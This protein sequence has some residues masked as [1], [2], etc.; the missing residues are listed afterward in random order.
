MACTEHTMYKLKPLFDITELNINSPIYKMRN[1]QKEHGSEIL[2]EGR[3]TSDSL[4]EEI[5]GRQDIL[6]KQIQEIKELLAFVKEKIT[7]KMGSQEI[8]SSSSQPNVEPEFFKLGVLHEV[9]LNA[10][11]KN[12]PNS[13][14]ALHKLWPDI[15]FSLSWH[16]HSSVKGFPKALKKFENIKSYP[17]TEAHVKIRVVWKQVWSDCELI[18][19]PLNSV[20]LLG[21]VN[22]LRFLN[23]CIHSKE[24]LNQ[25][26]E[27]YFQSK[28]DACHCLTYSENIQE[29]QECYNILSEGLDQ[30]KWLNG[31]N[32]SVLD[33]ACWSAINN[34]KNPH[35]TPLLS[36]WYKNCDNFINI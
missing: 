30:N 23:R 8:T 24:E 9:V 2:K 5:E 33:I 6:L 31:N 28:L 14:L 13:L 16:I 17:D 4:L 32:F 34:L 12:P 29:F 19:S 15:R 20:P 36:R 3:G 27:T 7:S 25:Y 35:L 11:V 10:S 21:E 18:I 26:D 22:F 1:I